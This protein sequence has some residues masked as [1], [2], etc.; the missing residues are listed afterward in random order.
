[1]KFWQHDETGRTYEGDESPGARWHEVRFPT[2]FA[3]PYPV[4]DE[5]RERSFD[6]L[7]G[8]GA[9]AAEYSWFAAGWNACRGLNPNTG[10]TSDA[11]VDLLAAV[12]RYCEL[13]EVDTGGTSAEEAYDDM[14]ALLWKMLGREGDPREWRDDR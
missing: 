3:F 5:E 2:R 10:A 12:D 14:K 13:S 8:P 7:Y 9:S 4:P 1:M 11:A 6:S